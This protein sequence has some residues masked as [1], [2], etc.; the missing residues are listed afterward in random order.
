MK[1]WKT[2]FGAVVVALVLAVGAMAQSNGSVNGSVEDAKGQPWQGVSVTLDNAKSG[3]HF[4][5]TTGAD[6]KFSIK[7]VPAGNYT[8][9]FDTGEY[10]PEPFQVQVK[11]GSALS[12]DLNF[13]KLIEK[14]PKL[15][16][17]LKKAKQFVL[18]KKHFSAGLQAMNQAKSL[19]AQL[20][21]EPAAQQS[22][23]QQQIAQLSQTAA[24]DFQQAQQ[25]AAPNDPNMPT[26]LGNLALAYEMAGK[27]DQAASA[28]A[29]AS[30]LKPTD[31]DLLLG[32]ATNLAYSG[33]I[34][35]ASADCDK[36]VA[37]SPQSGGS[38]WRNIGVVLYNTNQM[39]Q[40]VAPLQKA[41][42][43]DPSNAD[44]WYL[45]GE[46]LMNN[47]QSKMVNGKLTAVVA[48]GTA[49]A[50]QKYLQLAPN[51]PQAGNAKQALQVL[52]QLGGG[53]NSKF[54]APAGKKSKKH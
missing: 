31:P 30:Q 38:C 41:V 51:G 37:L 16:A 29:Q 48:P 1:H 24:T 20:N 43:A 10:P 12:E 2:T 13:Q 42:Q 8:L 9:T 27:H 25:V 34:Q 50:F 5:T 40:A 46:S 11:S 22:A 44:T 26:I 28:F 18:L 53:V 39:Q 49:E 35:E 33:K 54:V 3:A 6:G 7:N 47:M 32:A 17:E 45:L 21:N 14:N 15:A 19:Q 52:Q 36:V 23:T 4:A